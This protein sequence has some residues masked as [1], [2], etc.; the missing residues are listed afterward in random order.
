MTVH[1]AVLGTSRIVVAVITGLLTEVRDNI[2]FPTHF[3]VAAA[4]AA[5]FVSRCILVAAF[6]AFALLLF[7]LVFAGLEPAGRSQVP[8]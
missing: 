2:S 5:L 6:A 7:S 8:T 1:R 3:P 4:S